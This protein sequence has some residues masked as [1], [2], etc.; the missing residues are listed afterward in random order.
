MRQDRRQLQARSDQL[1]RVANSIKGCDPIANHLRYVVR[2]RAQRVDQ[3][4]AGVVAPC[5]YHS[6]RLHACAVSPRRAR[7]GYRGFYYR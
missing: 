5:H 7:Y 4:L 3:V 6:S 2:E 1:H